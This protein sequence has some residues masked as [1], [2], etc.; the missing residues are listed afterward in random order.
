MKKISLIFQTLSIVTTCV[1]L[2]VALFTTVLFPTESVDPI[3]L[4]Q[5]PVVSLLCA[6]GTLLYPSNRGMSRKEKGI[7][8]GLHYLLINV[9]VLGAGVLFDW[10]NASSLKSVLSMVITIAIVFAVVSV[11]T[12]TKASKD[13]KRMNEKLQEYQQEKLHEN[14]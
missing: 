3:I 1:L 6:L 8:I 14:P 12:W 2:A 13:A 7:R 11:A 5:I 4:W 10:Y 9:V